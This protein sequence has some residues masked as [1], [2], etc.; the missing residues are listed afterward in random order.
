MTTGLALLLALAC[1]IATSPGTR[2]HHR[3]SRASKG[4]GMPAC[5]F[6]GRWKAI[7]AKMEALPSACLS[8][9]SSH[10]CFT[11]NAPCSELLLSSHPTMRGSAEPPAD[12]KLRLVATGV[13]SR[14]QQPRAATRP[15]GMPTAAE[16]HPAAAC[17]H[18]K[19]LV[20][21]F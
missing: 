5:R 17:N 13:W 6:P 15:N 10:L 18:V 14:Q 11:K 16:H 19:L 20:C 21:P 4:R 8:D 12:G 7:A 9:L 1:T 3:A 2:V